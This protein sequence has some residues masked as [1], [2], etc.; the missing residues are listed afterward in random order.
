MLA[1]FGCG[2]PPP[3]SGLAASRLSLTDAHGVVQWDRVLAAL[4][5]SGGGDESEAESQRM[6]RGVVVARVREDEADIV[7]DARGDPHHVENDLHGRV[8]LPLRAAHDARVERGQLGACSEMR[9]PI[10]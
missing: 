4:D 10:S 9:L 7:A 5:G 6:A 2:A 3:L 8:E 1:A